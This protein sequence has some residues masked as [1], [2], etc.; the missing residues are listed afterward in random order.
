MQQWSAI[1]S[2]ASSKQH[3]RSNYFFMLTTEVELAHTVASSH[4]VDI[5]IQERTD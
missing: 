3:V 5:L 2:L 1:D 4:I